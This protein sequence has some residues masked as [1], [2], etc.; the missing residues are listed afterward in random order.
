M[1]LLKKKRIKRMRMKKMKILKKQLTVQKM[2]RISSLLTM[3]LK[4]LRQ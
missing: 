4:L 1:I 3:R 2:S